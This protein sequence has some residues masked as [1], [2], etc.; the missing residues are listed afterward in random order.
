MGEGTQF[1][2]G[3]WTRFRQ[4]TLSRLALGGLAVIHA[5]PSQLTY[6][7]PIHLQVRQ[8]A[9]GMRGYVLAG[10]SV[11]PRPTSMSLVRRGYSWCPSLNSPFFQSGMDSSPSSARV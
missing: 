6:S 8:P 4:L 2:N 5:R 3:E 7:A 10:K 1:L 11:S 9:G